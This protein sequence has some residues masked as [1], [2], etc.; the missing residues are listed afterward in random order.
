MDGQS[1]AVFQGHSEYATMLDHWLVSDALK[2]VSTSASSE[3]I[4]M[5]WRIVGR[6]FSND[7][8]QPRW[9]SNTNLIVP[10]GL[11]DSWSI[12]DLFSET[13]E[14]YA[15]VVYPNFIASQ[16][17]DGTRLIVT[18]NQDYSASSQSGFAIYDAD[19]EII[20]PLISAVEGESLPLFAYRLPGDFRISPISPIHWLHDSSG[21]YGI[22]GNSEQQH[23]I[24]F[25]RDG[26]I[27]NTIASGLFA[28]FD[29]SLDGSTLVFVP[30]ELDEN[31]R[32][33][34]GTVHIAN[35]NNQQIYDTCIQSAFNHIAV[36]PDGRQVAV[37]IGQGNGFV[38]VVDFD[39]AAAYRLNLAAN[40]VIAWFPDP[41]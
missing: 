22:A 23:I 31:G 32:Q 3:T 33:S 36:S 7:F 9:I 4:V 39:E 5:P 2:I 19:G 34:L 25:N 15:Y 41:E 17:P 6:S 24:F 38:Y 8:Y 29:L 28:S 1:F 13:I 37:G 11:S 26:V 35:M 21:F 30:F 20:T 18:N 40:D 12:I 16:S 27:Q 10:E 14:P